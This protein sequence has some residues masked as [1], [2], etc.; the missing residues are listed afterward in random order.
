MCAPGVGQ[1]VGSL[2]VPW[3]RGDAI[4]LGTLPDIL[5]RCPSLCCQDV[6]ARR[7]ACVCGAAKWL[8]AAWVIK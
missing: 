3:H 8:L 2:L 6:P 5:Y 7:D 4:I 1:M